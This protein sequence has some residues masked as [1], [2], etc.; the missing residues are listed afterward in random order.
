MNFFQKIFKKENYKTF[1]IILLI[2][3]SLK[4]CESCRRDNMLQWERHENAI[5]ID[6]LN[7]II[8]DQNIDI[9]VLNDSLKVLNNQIE[10]INHKSQLL[11][12]IN[13][14]QTITNKELIKVL[15]NRK[16]E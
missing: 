15:K 13:K 12:E 9:L 5:V 10:N 4:S 1:L 6:S 7:Q 11:Y 16:E 8:A 2:L 14:N 3:L